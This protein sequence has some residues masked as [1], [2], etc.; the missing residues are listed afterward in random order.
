VVAG[1]AARSPSA[2]PSRE[3]VPALTVVERSLERLTVRTKSLR[4]GLLEGAVLVG[5]ATGVAVT[6]NRAWLGAA[7]SGWLEIALL[8]ACVATTAI[9]LLVA[10]RAREDRIVLDLSAHRILFERR[11]LFGQVRLERVWAPG[12]RLVVE[13]RPTESIYQVSLAAPGRAAQ[14]LMAC[15]ADVETEQ[16]LAELRSF[17]ESSRN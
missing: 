3:V 17:L 4:G 16:V 14:P 7:S 13:R 15:H 5:L 6:A 10:L 2:E 11:S 1:G 8:C 12:S 9:G